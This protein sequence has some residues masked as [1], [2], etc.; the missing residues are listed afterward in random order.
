MYYKLTSANKTFEKSKKISNL[1]INGPK[2]II[3]KAMFNFN[4]KRYI[5]ESDMVYEINDDNTFNTKGARL[6]NKVFTTL[7]L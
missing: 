5:I 7:T 1:W 6:L 4:K 2:N 3:I